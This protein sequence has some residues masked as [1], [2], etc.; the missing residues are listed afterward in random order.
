MT[1]DKFKT[2]FLLA[3][4]VLPALSWAGDD[5]AGLIVGVSVE[6][7]LNKKASLSLETEF[8]SRNDFRTA[9]RVNVGISGDYK[10]TKWLKADAGYQL[11]I[12]NNREKIT[13]NPST[14]DEDGNEVVNYNNW[15]P[16][17]WGTRHRVFASL[18][19]SYRL[20]RVDF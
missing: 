9:D 8:R 7:K 16:S 6:K 18:T 12:D 15:R 20:G 14:V 17:Y 5:D 4:L 2:I 10:L 3:A 1:I 11:L 19:G 13:Y